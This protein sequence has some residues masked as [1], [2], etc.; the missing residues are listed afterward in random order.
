MFGTIQFV[1]NIPKQVMK[2]TGNIAALVRLIL[3]ISN[4]SNK[5]VNRKG[6]ILECAQCTKVLH[7]FYWISELRKRYV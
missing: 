1:Y 5:I 3:I 6:P 4:S 2:P 7:S